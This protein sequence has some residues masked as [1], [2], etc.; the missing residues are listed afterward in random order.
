[1][2]SNI[3]TQVHALESN[4]R[5]SILPKDRLACRVKQPAIKPTTIRLVLSYTWEYFLG[6]PTAGK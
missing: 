5:F 6:T 3:H 1:M 4:S 2:V